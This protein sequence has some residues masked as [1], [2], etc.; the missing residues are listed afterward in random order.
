ML[1]SLL[2]TWG[3]GA[4][5]SIESCI[6]SFHTTYHIQIKLFIHQVAAR[7]YFTHPLG[8]ILLMLG[9]KQLTAGLEIIL[10]LMPVKFSEC[11][12]IQRL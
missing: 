7:M 5:V 4:A 11:L 2:R 8:N 10:R 9:E 1:N 6:I 3:W 12:V